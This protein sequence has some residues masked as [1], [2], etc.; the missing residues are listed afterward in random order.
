MKALFPFLKR[1]TWAIGNAYQVQH[2]TAGA[3]LLVAIS[4]VVALGGT[5]AWARSGIQFASFTI[6]ALATGWL[7]ASAR[8]PRISAALVVCCGIPVWGALQLMLGAS[9]YDFATRNAILDS[10]VFGALFFIAVQTFENP[11]L[12][13]RLLEILFVFGFLVSAAALLWPITQFIDGGHFCVFI[14]LLLPIGLYLSTA[15]VD[16]ST[17]GRDKRIS[18]VWAALCA[19]LVASVIIT[20]C[21]AGCALI[22]AEIVAVP[23]IRVVG[24][25]VDKKSCARGVWMP[26]ASMLLL[27]A[28][29]A[30][31]VGWQPLASRFDSGDLSHGR[32][33]LVAAAVHMARDRPL[34]G[35]GLG[36]FEAVYPTYVLI[37]NGLQANHAHNDWAEWAATGGLP[38]L[39]LYVAVFGLTLPLLVRRIWAIGVLAM[40]LHALVDFPFE[41][42]ALLVLN[43]ILLGAASAG[44]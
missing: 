3:L 28:V 1:N 7:I 36:S 33:E 10:A 5:A 40:C 38:L 31:A 26:I 27:V 15:G 32:S 29:F 22:A 13:R 4:A 39:V 25:R 11:N 35:F 37:D 20:G 12:R 42:P 2:L 17:T 23:L 44:D 16:P 34:T 24:G 18:Y 6:A 9:V 19:S 8:A 14:E 41:I 21:G 43:A 30:A